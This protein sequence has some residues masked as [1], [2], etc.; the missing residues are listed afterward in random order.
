M[1]VYEP[2]KQLIKDPEKLNE[3]MEIFFSKLG[4]GARK[5]KPGS[6]SA[7]GY[8]GQ[9]RQEAEIEEMTQSM[10]KKQVLLDKIC[11]E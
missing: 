9:A 8:Y 5:P 11:Q 6:Y 10:N 2:D 1:L 4:R 7:Y 3:K